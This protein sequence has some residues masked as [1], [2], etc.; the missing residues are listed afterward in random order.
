M[1]FLKKIGKALNPIEQT[2]TT[3]RDPKQGLK[4]QWLHVSDPAGYYARAGT[5]RL[6]EPFNA[7]YF[8]GSAGGVAAN[9]VMEAPTPRAAYAPNR[10]PLQLSPGAQQLMQDM[11]ARAAARSAGQT[12]QAGTRGAPAATAPTAAV[13]PQ[14]RVAIDML[15]GRTGAAM[16]M[17]DGGKVGGKGRGP[18]AGC[19]HYES[20]SFA[21]KPNG[22]SC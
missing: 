10:R 14:P 19:E 16:L 9:P 2:K 6:N 20:K 12:Y 17:A 13:A 5:G 11:Q 22:K 8:A 18:L 4:E 21:R 1:G 15:R 3:L 7:R